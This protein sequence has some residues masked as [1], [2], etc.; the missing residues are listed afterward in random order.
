MKEVLVKKLISMGV[1]LVLLVTFMVPVAVGADDRCDY[2]PPDC[3]ALPEKT[4]RSL[5][6][7]AV[8]TAL[9]ATD[10]MGTAVA[11]TTG[12][13][14]CNLGGW[15][16]ELGIIAAEGLGVVLVELGPLVEALGDLIGMPDLFAPIASILVRLG[17][18]IAELNGD[19]G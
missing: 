10:I 1:V 14:A 3:P 6:G 13:L 5:A 12:M 9:S 19:N 17:E 8:W 16:D 7:A 4:T 11:Q 2:T 15:S 18:V